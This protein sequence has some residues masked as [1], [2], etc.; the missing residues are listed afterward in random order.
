MQSV[1]AFFVVFCSDKFNRFLQAKL[2]K[3]GVKS[4]IFDFVDSY[5][6]NQTIPLCL[7]NKFFT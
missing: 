7:H 3:Y 6:Y 2:K 1:W 4:P 5:Q